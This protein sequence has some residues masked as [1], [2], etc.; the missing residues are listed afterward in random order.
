M[1]HSNHSNSIV[2]QNGSSSS[3]RTSNFQ[4]GQPEKL[5]ENRPSAGL[6]PQAGRSKRMPTR[7]DGLISQSVLDLRSPLNSMR[8][9]IRQVR[10]GHFGQINP[11]QSEIL[12]SAIQQCE[13]IEQLVDEITQSERFSGG[14][15]P[16]NRQWIK[17]NG[18]R[19]ALE[20]T[21]GPWA[22]P[23]R[24]DVLWDDEVQIGGSAEPSVYADPSM[25]RRLIV[26]LVVNAIRASTEGKEV[27]IRFS[28]TDC[29]ECVRCSVI[30][31]GHGIDRE[32]LER[33]ASGDSSTAI[34]QGLGLTICSQLAASH[35][36]HLQIRSQLGVGTQVSFELPA[37]GPRSVGSAFAKWRNT[38]RAQTAANP[39][40]PRI[41]PRRRDASPQEQVQDQVTSA[42]ADSSATPPPVLMDTARLD[43]TRLDTAVQRKRS[44]DL[45][46]IYATATP[47]ATDVFAAGVVHVGAAVSRQ[48]ADQFDE[49][50]HRQVGVFEFIYRVNTRRWVWGF[51]ADPDRIGVRIESINQAV[52]SSAEGLRSTWT[53]PQFIPIEPKTTATRICDL[54][55]RQTLSA[56]TIDH[57]LGNDEVRLGTSPIAPS[58]SA[59]QRLDEELRRLSQTMRS[60]TLRLKQQSQKLK[61]RD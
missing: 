23:K 7:S 19:T 5:R 41:R 21:L 43:T 26:N 15:P 17:I 11:D 3:G 1:N 42:Y 54:I 36:S 55:V 24:I 58:D 47:Q 52:K 16:A 44:S 35:F 29:G 31:Q 8:E 46:L 50:I 48:A 38:L 9:S 45:R 37:A 10:Q 25:I 57:G 2:P 4:A 18:I 32:H 39:I 30:D 14:S 34:Q 33:I 51:D 53:D 27:L 20:E 13:R 56:S 22:M 60:Q 6:K 49:I 28:A 61:P 40:R 12:G 59:S